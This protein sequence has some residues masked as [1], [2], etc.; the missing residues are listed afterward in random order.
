MVPLRLTLLLPGL[1]ALEL[2]LSTYLRQLVSPLLATALMSGAVLTARHAFA[3]D[4]RPIERLGVSV[5][6]G[7]V[8]YVLAILLLD[9]TL[10]SDLR[11]VARDLFSSSKA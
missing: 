10:G 9:R 8:T 1:W 7:A 5:G 2:R 11:D 6:V 3:A 4:D